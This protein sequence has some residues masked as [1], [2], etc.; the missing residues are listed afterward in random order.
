MSAPGL[1]SR[2]EA[3][4]IPPGTFGHRQHLQSAFE[5]LQEH[6]FLDAASRYSAAIRRFAE[7]AGAPEKFSV[8]VTLAY[9]SLIAERMAKRRDA[10]FDAFLD[11]N[12]D[13]LE[14][15]LNRYY[16]PERLRSAQARTVLLLPD[17]AA[18]SPP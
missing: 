16:S 6:E 18:A 15:V 7:A 14:N 17:R 2:L 3:L 10:S 8:T 4:A 1:M 11:A 5:V 9:L 12:P 13:L